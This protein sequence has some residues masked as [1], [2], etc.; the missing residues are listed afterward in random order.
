MRTHLE[1]KHNNEYDELKIRENEKRG[2]L[3][4]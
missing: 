2:V 1:T 3:L 4:K